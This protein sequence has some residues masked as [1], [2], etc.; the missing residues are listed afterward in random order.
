M[1][2]GE[3][4]C[5]TGSCGLSTQSSGRI[6]R[7]L[8]AGTTLKK[9]KERQRVVSDRKVTKITDLHGHRSKEDVSTH[10]SHPQVNPAEI[11]GGDPLLHMTVSRGT[12]STL[13]PEKDPTPPWEHPGIPSSPPLIT[14]SKLPLPSLGRTKIV[15]YSDLPFPVPLLQEHMQRCCAQ[16]VPCMETAFLS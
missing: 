10:A 1:W 13:L 3:K 5:L 4:C 16:T 14:N 11:R 7:L 2:G 15:I 12:S 9:R 8:D 6:N